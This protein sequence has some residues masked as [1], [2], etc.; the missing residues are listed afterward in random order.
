MKLCAFHQLAAFA[1]AAPVYAN[2]ANYRCRIENPTFGD[3]GNSVP[4]QA[5]QS[6]QAVLQ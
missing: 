6:G 2:P 1:L 5:A 4:P 3:N